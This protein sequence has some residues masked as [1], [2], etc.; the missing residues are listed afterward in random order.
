ME[1]KFGKSDFVKR[2]VGVYSVSE[3]CAYLSGGEIVVGKT[4]CNGITVAVSK[5]MI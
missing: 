1:E 3:P 5:E 4:K 2:N